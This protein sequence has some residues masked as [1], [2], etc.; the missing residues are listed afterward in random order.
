MV[1][2]GEQS[3]KYTLHALGDS[4][5]VLQEM[6][7][8]NITVRIILGHFSCFSIWAVAYSYLNILIPI[9]LWFI[10]LSHVPSQSLVFYNDFVIAWLIV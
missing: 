1:Q 8:D 10:I 3:G 2:A 5:E 4:L 7:T 6:H 9:N